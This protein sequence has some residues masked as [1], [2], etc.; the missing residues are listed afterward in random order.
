MDDVARRLAG[1]HAGHRVAQRD[2]LVEGGKG[3]ETDAPTKCRL[4][5]EQACERGAAVELGI[6]QEA[7]AFELLGIEQVGLIQDDHHLASPFVLF[8]GE[9]LGGLRDERGPVEP[10]CPPE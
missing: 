10:G 1:V 7:Q 2:T 6:G 3:T 9:G 4:A 5:D 8:G